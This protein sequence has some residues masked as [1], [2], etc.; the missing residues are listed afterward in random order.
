MDFLKETDFRFQR[1]DRI[2]LQGSDEIRFAAEFRALWSLPFAAVLPVDYLQQS[3]SERFRLIPSSWSFAG[4]GSNH[5]HTFCH[6]FCEDPAILPRLL[7]IMETPL[8]RVLSFNRHKKRQGPPAKS[9][10]VSYTQVKIQKHQKIG[11]RINTKHDHGNDC[12]Q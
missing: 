10:P 2:P 6:L 9:F 4:T 3:C 11:L 8:P 7:L 12:N 5:S 1:A